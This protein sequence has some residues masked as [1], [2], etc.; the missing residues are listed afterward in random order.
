MLRTVSSNT[1][2]G[3]PCTIAFHRSGLISVEFRKLCI[4]DGMKVKQWRKWLSF[5]ADRLYIL[6]LNSA[7]FESRKNREGNDNE[8]QTEQGLRD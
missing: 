7:A 3:M 5:E 8:A 4:L 6:I 1:P 2:N